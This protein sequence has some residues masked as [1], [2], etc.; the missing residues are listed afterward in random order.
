MCG[1]VSGAL[2]SRKQ[3]VHVSIK[4][5]QTTFSPLRI[6]IHA[7]AKKKCQYR[8]SAANPVASRSAWDRILAKI[9]Q[10]YAAAN[11]WLASCYDICH[12]TGFDLPTFHNPAAACEKPPRDASFQPHVTLERDDVLCLN[13]NSGYAVI[14]VVQG[15]IWIT[16]TP[17]RGDILLR[18]GER[19][20]L[21]GDWPFVLQALSETTIVLLWPTPVRGRS[22][23]FSF[24][25]S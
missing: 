5:D 23:A 13:H 17:A 15:T 8:L 2:A 25:N 19:F 6:I 18:P 16:S 21:R 1:G 4:S 22:R 9:R 10:I 11:A 3:A 14:Q 24:E 7:G 12:R 20:Q